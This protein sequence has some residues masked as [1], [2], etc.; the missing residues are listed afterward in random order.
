MVQFDNQYRQIKI[1]IVYYGPALGGKTTSLQYIHHATDPDRRT[2]L[3]SLNT[4]NDRTLF[5]D[6]LSLNLG[7]IRG[8]RLTMQLY[9]VPGQVQYN[10][11]RRAVLSGAD[12]IVFVADSQ[13]DQAAANVE[14]LENLWENL[15]ANGIDR[16]TIPV[17]FEY[18]KRDLEPLLSIAAMD[19]ALNPDSAVPAFPCVATTGDGVIEAFA[20]VSEQAL[21]AVADKLGVGNNP[22]AVKR[23]QEQVRVAMQP[24]IGPAESTAPP[25]PAQSEV[26]RPD[27]GHDADQ[28]LAQETL[29]QEAVR[30]NVAMTDL[31]ARLDATR[32]QLERKVRVLS[33]ITTFGQK[34][35][36]TRD[37][38]EVLQVFM[39]AACRSLQV[40]ASAVSLTG[41][42]GGLRETLVHKLKQDPMVRTDT[43]DGE[44][45]ATRI[46]EQRQPVLVA[47]ELAEV[48]S[49][50]LLQTVEDAG[51]A[52]G[53]AV[54][55]VAQ[56]Q[57]I[58]LLTLYRSDGRRP[59]D[60][61][62]LQFASAMA[63]NAAVA[64]SNAVNWQRLEDLNRD[65]EGQ[66]EA[67]TAELRETLE[68]VQRL[69]RDLQEKN[70][71]LER[72]Y[73]ELEE[74]DR[75][76]NELLSRISHELK[77]PVTSLFTAAKILER[78]KD[79]PPEKGAR[80][81][82][83]IREEAEKLSEIIQSVFQAAI[84]AATDEGPNTQQVEV[85]ELFKQAIG[86]L[87]DLAK[88]R[89]VT[90]QV[91]ISSELS[92]VSCD[93]EMM[94]T[95]LRAVVK[96]AVEFNRSGGE[97]TVEARR[98]LV[99]EH[100]MLV[101]KVTDTGIGI[102]DKELPHVWEVF[103]QGGNVLTG[104]PR[105]VGLGLA[106]AK[107]VVEGHGGSVSLTSR[108]G[109]GTEVQLKVPIND[110]LSHAS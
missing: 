58:G 53:I 104:K 18:N 31:N 103:W 46:L 78:Y 16:A 5:F 45:V 75:V 44:S 48:E 23:L 1:K 57:I 105:G 54:P 32:Q 109:E 110:S 90:L 17:V 86:P 13:T 47:R 21:A 49:S 107:R 59:F 55:L 25:P 30:A 29:V 76:K 38:R 40:Q 61:D 100:T 98:A 92:T 68:E 36:T 67:R 97:V 63:T 83:I 88:E 101:I 8:Y 2:K 35:T 41:G 15:A 72:A 28:P 11:T 70:A 20:A 82:S 91:R 3:Y 12:A 9:T 51:F 6:L 94:E 22:Q 52:T 19:E 81:I 69:N 24:Y 39:S 108:V 26:H 4:A 89:D 43:G 84:L 56:N 50:L 7:R 64:Y 60:D 37:P 85:A 99:D 77:T 66:V 96:N 80:F 73:R 14:S 93:T 65:L 71:L 79:A 87:R 102:P 10:A 74:V 27:V 62:D 106:I 95:A 34:L 42:G 33:D